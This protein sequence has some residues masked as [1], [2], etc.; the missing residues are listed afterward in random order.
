MKKNDKGLFTTTITY[1]GKR[2][3][4]R[5]KTQKELWQKAA[6]RQR[7]LE[8]GLIVANGNTTVE[9]WA[10]EWL[11]TYKKDSVRRGTYE[12]Y[13]STIERH[14]IKHM[15]GVKMNAVRPVH[16][17]KIINTMSGMSSDTVKKV[18]QTFD[19]VF[20]RARANG[21]IATNPAADLDMPKTAQSASRRA[22]TD[23]ER[24]HII[25][26]SKT[27]PAGLWVKMILYCGLRPE[28][29]IPLQWIHL[30]LDDD[31][32]FLRVELAAEART[33]D[34]KPPKSAAGVRSIPIPKIYADE[35]R[36]RRPL[37]DPFGYVFQRRDGTRHTATTLRTLWRDFKDAV[38]ISMGAQVAMVES[39]SKHAA[40]A[41]RIK[42]VIVKSVVASDLVP[43]CLRHTYC[44]DLQAAG[45]PINV[46]RE[47]MGHSDISMT[48][49]IYTH[50]SQAALDNA[51]AA[52]DAYL[53]ATSGATA[54]GQKGAELGLLED[55]IK[56]RA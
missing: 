44:T 10:R 23:E 27:H 49:K 20:D 55:E 16:L 52:V 21:I 19:A 34:I 7:D 35:L 33:G 39:Q 40:K 54:N 31:R 50:S 47:L 17:Q 1:G 43:Y 37:N 36:T 13:Q 32:P 53:G 51:A 56:A 6:Q 24:K 12:R 4:I 45:V 48:A 30:S 2:Y 28:E 38:D 18:I 11:E 42:S 25:E 9:A 5:A 29:T 46:A 15:G 3:Y 14:L 22:I 8:A 41:N 26:A